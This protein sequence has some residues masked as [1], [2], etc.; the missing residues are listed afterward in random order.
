[1]IADPLCFLQMVCLVPDPLSDPLLVPGS[2][3]HRGVLSH[4]Q[5]RTQ[6]MNAA[7]VCLLCSDCVFILSTPEDSLNAAEFQA[8]CGA[9]GS[10]R[11]YSGCLLQHHFIEFESPI[12]DFPFP[13]L[14]NVL[15]PDC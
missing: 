10:S 7:G 12:L 15:G 11:S 6:G 14:E 3:G 5:P 4:L 13:T 9:P 8:P 1:M 2:M